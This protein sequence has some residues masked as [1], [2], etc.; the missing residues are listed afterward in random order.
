[1]TGF[2]LSVE[3]NGF[4]RSQDAVI[5]D[6]VDRGPG[7]DRRELFHELDRLEHQMGR[8]IAPRRLEFDEDASVSPEAHTVLGQRGTEKIATKLLQAD[9]IV[10][11]DPDVGVE[12]EA[13]ELGLARAAGGRVTGIRRVSEAP[14]TG[15]GTGAKGDAALDGRADDPGQDGR[16]LAEG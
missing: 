16:G 7:R 12:V 13:I 15:A 2:D 5:H 10:R 11:G 4:P 14:D 9:A 6:Q 8:A 3:C 1:M